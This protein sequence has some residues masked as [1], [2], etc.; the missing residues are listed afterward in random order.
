MTSNIPSQANT[1]NSKSVN[2]LIVTS[3]IAK[4]IFLIKI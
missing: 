4:Y 3:G 2:L 1:M